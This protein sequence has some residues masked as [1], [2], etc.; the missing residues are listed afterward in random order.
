MYIFKRWEG[1]DKM[2][3]NYFS[4]SSSSLS[5]ST[6]KIYNEGENKK[7]FIFIFVRN[8]KFSLFNIRK[9][10][11]LLCYCFFFVLIF[12][13]VILTRGKKNKTN[14]QVFFCFI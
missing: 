11:L 4:S 13:L 1:V 2:M 7:I 9:M 5:S 12:F 8:N 6:N 14:I 10:N 3:M